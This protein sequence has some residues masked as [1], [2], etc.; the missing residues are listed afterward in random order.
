MNS[1]ELSEIL[2]TRLASSEIRLPLS[3][4]F[5]LTACLIKSTKIGSTFAGISRSTS[6]FNEASRGKSK[7]STAFVFKYGPVLQATMNDKHRKFMTK[8]S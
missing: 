4:K 3:D 2:I 7:A 1:S 6:I 8:E 5:C